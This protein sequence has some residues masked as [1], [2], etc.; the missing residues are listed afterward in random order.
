VNKPDGSKAAPRTWEEAESEVRQRM[1]KIGDL[2]NIA[3]KLSTSASINDQTAEKLASAALMIYEA[4]A[5]EIEKR[6]NAL[7]ARE[8]QIDRIV[9]EEIIVRAA[10][11]YPASLDEFLRRVVGGKYDEGLHLYRNFLT[12]NIKD[13]CAIRHEP[14][15]SEEVILDE[16]ER[17]IKRDRLE[18]LTKGQYLKKA[19]SFLKWRATLPT[20]KARNAANARHKKAVDT[21]TELP[22][23]AQATAS[24]SASSRNGGASNK[25]TRRKQPKLRRK[26]T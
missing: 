11:S 24:V 3:A 26:Q 8:M 10:K 22:N 6:V 15:P 5:R 14:E 4:S 19:A 20:Q 21:A 2:A 13:L 1:P 17:A 16:L 7:T 9:G 18:P 23:Q 25:T 12:S